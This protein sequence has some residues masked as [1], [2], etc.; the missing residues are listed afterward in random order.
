MVAASRVVVATPHARHDALEQS[1]RDRLGLAVLRVRE[2]SG[3]QPA[4]LQSFR[5]DYVFFPHWS[6][7]I[8]A[9]VHEAFECVIFHMTDLPFGRGGSP[10]QNLIVRGIKETQLTA[11][12]CVSELDA[13]PI[14]M[15][16]PLSLLGT[17]EEILLRAA[18]LTEVMIERLVKERP[19]AQPQSG[20]VTTFRRRTP[21]DG[22]VAELDSL[23]KLFDHI[24]MLDAIGYPP[25]FLETRH[26]RY[27]FSRASLKPD[28]VIADV[29]I[30]RK[31]P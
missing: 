21:K 3:L 30:S 10:L 17:A 23:D 15:K 14:Y 29:K 20:D 2:P 12:R 19:V 8:P 5:P 1:L 24:R 16:M 31:K 26:F 6:W 9:E 4:V 28:G 27:E 22:D 11:L 13:G 18:D 7:M 25:A